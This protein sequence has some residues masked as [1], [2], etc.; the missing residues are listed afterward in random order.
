MFIGQ[1]SYLKPKYFIMIKT[2]E[3]VTRSL[4]RI[5]GEKEF[6]IESLDGMATIIEARDTFKSFVDASFKQWG[7]DQPGRITNET[8]MDVYE[9][10]GQGRFPE[11]YARLTANLDMAMVTQ[12]QII[13]FCERYPM[14]FHQKGYCYFFLIKEA[15]EYFMVYTKNNS[16]GL[17]ASLDRFNGFVN[18]PGK[19]CHRRIIV[20]QLILPLV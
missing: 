5:S 18:W 2:L 6:V 7:L 9:I 14:L 10:V 11:V 1:N 16:S 17:F 3:N 4:N 15:R 13:R 20:P 12:H 8:I 19:D